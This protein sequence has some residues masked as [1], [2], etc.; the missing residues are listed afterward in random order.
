MLDTGRLVHQFRLVFIHAINLASNVLGDDF[1]SA[2]L[3]KGML[4]LLGSRFGPGTVI[5]GG[6]YVYGG[7]LVTGASCFINR[8]CYFDFNARIVFGDNVVVGHGVTFI[9]AVHNIGGPARRAA[10][11][12]G[13]HAISVGDGAWIGANAT[14]LPGVTVGKGAVVAAGSVVNRNVP[15]NVIVAGVPSKVIKS[16]QDQPDVGQAYS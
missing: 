14:I 13:G 9:T 6:G 12:I 4:Q 8:G 11:Q 3:R 7:D 2:S 16:V 5:R 15:P 10:R 1:L